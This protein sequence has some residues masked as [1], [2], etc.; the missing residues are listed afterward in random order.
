MS[1]ALAPGGLYQDGKTGVWHDAQGNVI[2]KADAEAR[3]AEYQRL[4]KAAGEKTLAEKHDQSEAQIQGNE[5]R[6]A[7]RAEERARRAAGGPATSGEKASAGA[8]SDAGGTGTP[9]R[10]S[11]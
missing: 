11:K 5:D 8:S 10:T 4:Q 3:V 1:D 7:L 9:G 2:D 6:A